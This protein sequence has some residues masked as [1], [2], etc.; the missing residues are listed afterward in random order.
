[1][2]TNKLFLSF[3]GALLCV[4][5]AAASVFS[6]PVVQA[7]RHEA[8][9]VTARREL[10]GKKEKSES[11]KKVNITKQSLEV[12]AGDVKLL[13]AKGSEKSPVLYWES[14]DESVAEVDDGGRADFITPGSCRITAC[15][16]NG[17]RTEY[18]ATVSEAAKKA[19]PDIFTT[20]ITDNADV[21]ARNKK[22]GKRALYHLM[23]NTYHNVVTVYTYDKD[24]R[25]TVPV[26]AMLCSC[27]KNDSTIK[28]EFRTY[29]K[30]EWHALYNN[31]Y[32]QYVTGI[33]GD[34]LFHSVPYCDIAYNKLEVEEFNKLGTQASMGC[35]RLSVADSKWI[36]DNCPEGTYVKIY[37]SKKEEPLGKPEAIRIHNLKC[38]WDP[39][40]RAYKSPYRNARPKIS[41]AENIIVHTG[42]EPDL[43]KNIK[44]YDSCG[45]DITKKLKLKGNVDF[46]REGSYKL[47]LSVTDALHRSASVDIRVT[48][49]NKKGG[50]QNG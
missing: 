1:M 24:G 27:G 41:G 5:G 36:Y 34:F 47:T 50:K 16:K 29:F 4:A 40:E 9:A 22:S 8:A 35:V 21:L 12:S 11:V 15:L 20:A 44:A 3:L 7:E 31:V 23:V 42:E 2:N 38:G 37:N 6:V 26:R 17:D 43:K 48:V 39:T 18:E 32:G 28:G 30:S 45:N 19:S 10:S 13:E 33:S 14:S 46:S 49:V 25:Y